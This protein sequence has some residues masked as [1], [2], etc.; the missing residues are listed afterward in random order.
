ML[1]ICLTLALLGLA[2]VQCACGEKTTSADGSKIDAA[3][4]VY[5][6]TH[7]DVMPAFSDGAGKAIQ[8]YAA[9]SRKDKGAI[10]IEGLVQDGR[11]NHFTI[12]E[13][14]Q[15]REA[16]EAHA[17]TAHAHEFRDTLQ[18]ML[19]APFDERLHEV[20]P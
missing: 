20:L 7:I 3:K 19:G 18:P 4:N 11:P 8:K 17:G 2:L 13:T 14:W 6:V 1:S 9:E 15:N 12:V 5:I 16:F 10:G